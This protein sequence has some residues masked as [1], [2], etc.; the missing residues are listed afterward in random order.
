MQE[1]TYQQH[2]IVLQYRNSTVQVPVREQLSAISNGQT[3][4]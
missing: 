4:V 3:T 1:L 2:K